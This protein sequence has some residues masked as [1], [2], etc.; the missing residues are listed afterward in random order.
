MCV[1]KFLEN[2]TEA[3]SK[4]QPITLVDHLRLLEFGDQSNALVIK[5][6]C[7]EDF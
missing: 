7:A 2:N 4:L 6:L 3:V 1:L 5:L